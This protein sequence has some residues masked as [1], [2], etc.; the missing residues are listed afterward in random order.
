MAWDISLS[1]RNPRILGSIPIGSNIVPPQLGMLPESVE[2]TLYTAQSTQT[3]RKSLRT[4]DVAT[5]NGCNQSMAYLQHCPETI[6]WEGFLA[7]AMPA[8]NAAFTKCRPLEELG[9]NN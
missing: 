6:R 4:Q 2:V 3:H 5:I 7:P 1:R 8:T 9:Q